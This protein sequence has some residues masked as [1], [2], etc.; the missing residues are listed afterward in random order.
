MGSGRTL[1]FL[2]L[3]QVTNRIRTTSNTLT[4][5]P[6]CTPVAKLREYIPNLRL[7]VFDLPE[8]QGC[9]SCDSAHVYTK[10]AA[11]DPRLHD[12]IEVLTPVFCN[13]S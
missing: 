6:P 2:T 13:T 9:Q 5:I 3:N 1:N 10:P 4:G 8:L 7:G 11:R 12:D